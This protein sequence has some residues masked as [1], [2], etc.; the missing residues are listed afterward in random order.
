MSALES[1]LANLKEQQLM[2][3]SK[4]DAKIDPTCRRGIR[5]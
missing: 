1:R 5:G 3:Q 2:L 4:Y